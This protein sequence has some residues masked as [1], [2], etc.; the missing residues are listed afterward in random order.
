MTSV[1]C[2]TITQELSQTTS[3]RDYNKQPN[4]I[5]ADHIAE[6]TKL[7]VTVNITDKKLPSLYWIPK[8]HKT[9]YKSRLSLIQ[10]LA[11]PS[12]Y[13]CILHLH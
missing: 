4:E 6:C 11:P 13:Q 10:C 1:L 5:I 7:N 3:Y 9:P 8:L 2:Q 12:N